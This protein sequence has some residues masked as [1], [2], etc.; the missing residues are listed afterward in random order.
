MS[1]EPGRS[2][3]DRERRI[4]GWPMA[5]PQQPDESGEEASRSKT[6]QE[7]CSTQGKVKYK[8]L[9]PRKYSQLF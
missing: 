4:V 8:Y 2:L 7:V 5:L 6:I 3:F 1:V 9:I